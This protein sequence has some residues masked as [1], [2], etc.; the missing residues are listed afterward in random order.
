[1]PEELKYPIGCYIQWNER[2]YRVVKNA[3]DDVGIVLNSRGRLTEFMFNCRGMKS[4]RITCPVRISEL[5]A[6]FC[7]FER[8]EL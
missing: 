5:N 1:M 4:E 8:W 7:V 6:E 3:F 2:C